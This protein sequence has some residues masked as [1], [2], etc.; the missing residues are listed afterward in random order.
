M[1]GS[2]ISNAQAALFWDGTCGAYFVGTAQDMAVQGS[3]QRV[4]KISVAGAGAGQGYGAPAALPAAAPT[5]PR[6]VVRLFDILTSTAE[7]LC[8]QSGQSTLVACPASLSNALTS[9]G[10]VVP[11]DTDLQAGAGE[12]WRA[13]APVLRTL[14]HTGKQVW[15][16]LVNNTYFWI[17]PYGN[18][19]ADGTGLVAP[20]V[21]IDLNSLYPQSGSSIVTNITSVGA[22]EPDLT[23]VLAG[24]CDIQ[25]DLNPE[26]AT[27]GAVTT[28]A[29]K[30][31]MPAMYTMGV[32]YMQAITCQ[33]TGNATSPKLLPEDVDTE[34]VPVP[35]SDNTLTF[36]V[37]VSRSTP[38]AG[39]AYVPA[40]TW[41]LP[42]EV[43]VGL[44]ADA[45]GSI[46]DSAANAQW[47]SKCFKQFTLT[48]AMK[49]VFQLWDLFE[50][51]LILGS[52]YATLATDPNS[53]LKESEYK[54]HAHVRLTQVGD[55][56]I[57]TDLRYDVHPIVVD[58]VLQTAIVTF[59]G[60]PRISTTQR[61]LT[62]IVANTPVVVTSPPRASWT[63]T[64][65]VI[66][67]NL[68]ASV[69]ASLYSAALSVKLTG[70]DVSSAPLQLSHQPLALMPQGAPADVT[71]AA[72]GGNDASFG[73]A[74]WDFDV[75]D[76]QKTLVTLVLQR[77]LY[78]SA[79][80]Q[81]AM[82][83]SAK[84]AGTP[85]QRRAALRSLLSLGAPKEL[86][87]A[88]AAEG[89]DYVT[90]RALQDI[91]IDSAAAGKKAAA[92]SSGSAA[93]ASP[94]S[95]SGSGCS[96]S[97]AS[98]GG[99]GA[100]ASASSSSGSAA[101]APSAG[102]VAA[103]TSNAN[104][105]AGD[106]NSSSSMGFVGIIVGAVGGAMVVSALA[107]LVVVRMRRS[108]GRRVHVTESSNLRTVC[109]APAAAAAA[110]VSKPST[111]SSSPASSAVLI[112]DLETGA[113]PQLVGA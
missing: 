73:S 113:A 110:A 65:D 48:D 11:V 16:L 51:D 60:E 80:Y 101:A 70:V 100:G 26:S 84:L 46:A 90:W 34:V 72:F 57:R 30:I 32:D 49:G 66:S 53:G 91:V 47:L 55:D 6:T 79:R 99:A 67:F 4:L 28:V 94:A 103:A 41:H 22:T 25:V 64:N 62:S 31:L 9:S 102:A 7:G 35:G 77:R 105:A 78:S 106:S 108:A 68:A 27:R 52:C 44:L 23:V 86:L 3:G 83:F 69:S 37:R 12:V 33:A 50:S 74:F 61:N 17:G 54:L 81:V 5:S 24:Q 58:K 63:V 39:S 8:S 98:T 92:A 45:A 56:G 59:N 18:K 87:Q 112:E 1:G 15:T 109:V 14:P 89:R 40:M 75:A 29:N 85:Q 96:S 93:P 38:A 71:P 10:I 36:R 97:G 43:E 21:S 104:A 95:T 13:N 42:V 20:A 82:T 2:D 76:K 111:A 107:A 88:A 19:T